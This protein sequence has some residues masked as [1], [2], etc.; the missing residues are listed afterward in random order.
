MRGSDDDG[1]EVSKKNIQIHVN[2]DIREA[3]IIETVN[4]DYQQT[5]LI[6]NE[7]QLRGRLNNRICYCIVSLGKPIL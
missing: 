5:W 7:D 6:T 3:L 1:D 4:L 2:S